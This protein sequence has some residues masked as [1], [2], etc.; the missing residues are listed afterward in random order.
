VTAMPTVRPSP[1]IGFSSWAW[2]D[3]PLDYCIDFAIEHDFEAIEVAMFE[4]AAFPSGHAIPTEREAARAGRRLA[5]RRVT[6]HAPMDGI[7]LGS[8]DADERRSGAVLLTSAL[9]AAAG[10]AA[11]IVVVHLL[12]GAAAPVDPPQTGAS[13]DPMDLA[14]AELRDLA[15][16][17]AAAG[18]VIGVENIGFTGNAIDSDYQ[19]LAGLIAAIDHPAV[20]L[21]L[22]VGHANVHKPA[23]GLRATAE[24]LGD[25][26]RHYHVHDNGGAEDE[27]RRLGS[28]TI[29]LSPL[30]DTW[31]KTAPVLALEIFPHH[32]T[33]VAAGILESRS[34]LKGLLEATSTRLADT[35]HPPASHRAAG[36]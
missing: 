36:N 26:V 22:D 24:M 31:G 2:P 3:Q 35:A 9:R 13:P 19:R 17:A 32:E 30:L 7:Y 10:L 23:G 12:S 16:V 8:A 25:H 18:T 5:D 33:D 6:A 4:P 28:G 34:L 11:E 29:D 14:L 21:A 15:D 1:A 20:A 27:H